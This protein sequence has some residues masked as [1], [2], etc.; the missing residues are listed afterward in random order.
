MMRSDMLGM[1][2][3]DIGKL[4]SLGNDFDRLKEENERLWNKVTAIDFD[5][6][7]EKRNSIS[8]NKQMEWNPNTRINRSISN[9]RKS[10]AKDFIIGRS[11]TQVEIDAQLF[12]FLGEFPKLTNEIK[13]DLEIRPMLESQAVQLQVAGDS[14]SYQWVNEPAN[15]QGKYRHPIIKGVGEISTSGKRV[16][17]M[18]IVHFFG[19]ARIAII[20]W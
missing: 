9:L 17:F 12:R 2:L 20:G 15:A 18:R 16:R 14:R 6:G 7:G 5:Q 10:E 3:R 19:N 8:G 4:F 1:N 11:G 13:R